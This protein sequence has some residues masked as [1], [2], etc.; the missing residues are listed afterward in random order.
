[1]QWYDRELTAF[2][3]S[4][5]TAPPEPLFSVGTG[6]PL[7]AINVIN[8][9]YSGLESAVKLPDD[10]ADTFPQYVGLKQGCPL[11]PLLF[12]I[13]INDLEDF[14]KKDGHGILIGN[15]E[16]SSL[17]FEDNV[18]LMANN[19][20]DLQRL[21]NG[22]AAYSL[23]WGLVVNTNKTQIIIFN[24]SGRIIAE[25]FTYSN[26]TLET[27]DK[28]VYLGIVFVPSGV[29]TPTQSGQSQ[30]ASSALYYY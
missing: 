27:V 19:A 18:V 7:S 1:M 24:K 20:E 29:F 28:F 6:A 8:S 23:Q 21:I 17:L 13:H 22:M 10:V 25:T 3:M 14:L 2:G 15:K 9:M 4:H 11:S 5:T 12:N 26:I 16:I 30:K